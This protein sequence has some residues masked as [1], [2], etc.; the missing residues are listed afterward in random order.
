M[1][2]VMDSRQS[3]V[4]RP[5]GDRLFFDFLQPLSELTVTVGS[6]SSPVGAAAVAQ[7]R[8]RS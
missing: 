6:S 8:T 5:P 2:Q 7:Q 3:D 4:S 1:M